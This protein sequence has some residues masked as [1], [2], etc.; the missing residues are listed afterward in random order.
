[1]KGYQEQEIWGQ[2]CADSERSRIEDRGGKK[3]ERDEREK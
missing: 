3:E 2:K 1:M